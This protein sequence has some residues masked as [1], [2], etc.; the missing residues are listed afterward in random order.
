MKN[1]TVSILIVLLLFGFLAGFFAC[2]KKLYPLKYE[3]EIMKISSEFS[4]DSE[5][6][7]SLINIESG[8]NKFAV[9][10]AGAKGLM[11]LKDETALEVSKKLNLEYNPE[12]VFNENINIKIGCFYLKY[13]IDYYNGNINFA[14]SAY[15]AGMGRVD[16]W[17]E[18]NF[19]NEEEFIKSIPFAE[20]RNYL[21]KVKNGSK[22]YNLLYGL[23]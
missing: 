1:L 11:Q 14:L 18:E 22:I 2:F 4:L 12:D 16:L 17:L 13:L 10:S 23:T 15:N 21:S 9:S 3:E 7:A 5:L 8:F 6:V 20:T 19:Y